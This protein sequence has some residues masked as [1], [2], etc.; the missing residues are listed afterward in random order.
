MARVKIPYY[1]IKRGQ[2]YWQPTKAMRAAGFASIPC[3]PHGPKAWE[4]AAEWNLR[5]QRHKSGVEEPARQ[6]WPPRSIGDAFERYQATTIWANKKP[7]TR[8][9]WERGFARISPVFGDMRPV[10]AGISLET[11]SVFRDRILASVSPREAW[12]T[13]KIWRAIWTVCQAMGYTEGRSDPSKGIQ[14]SQ[15]AGKSTSWA[16]A[17]VVALVKA[18]WRMK[19]Y[20]LA[21]VIAVSWDTMLSPADIRA[22]TVD[23]LVQDNAGAYFTTGRAK[24]G[25]AAI[26]TLSR[27]TE[28]VLRAYLAIRPLSVG[29]IF[30][31]RSGS[32]Y[33]RFTLPDDF[34]EV[35][36]AA[37]PTDTRT[38]S[39]M[40]RSGAMEARAG[41]ADPATLS[42]KM[43]NNISVSNA[44]HKAYQP[45]D[46]T[47]VRQAD[48]A[49]GAGRK[50]MI[51]EAEAKRET[52]NKEGISSS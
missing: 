28:K 8:E 43:A 41:G 10:D 50:K 14:N 1:V 49:R 13:I 11:L 30:R 36:E 15:P 29:V 38:L 45:V 39:D 48:L 16:Y 6:K 42:A 32:P 40:R 26:G 25:R 2:G 51:A 4:I 34:K 20:G 12:R 7:R 33:S 19:H 17:E 3:G 23:K 52:R 27:R 21:A 5:W 44:L 35:R 24:T 37:F 18:A 46:L 9:E 22:L 31:N 47:S